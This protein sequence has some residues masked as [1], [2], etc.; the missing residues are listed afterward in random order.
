[1]PKLY[2]F[3]APN[4]D[5]SPDSATA[6]RLGSIFSGA[7]LKRL[8]SPLNQSEYVTIPS[9]L[10]NSSVK[11][12]FSDTASKSVHASGGA[13]AEDTSGVARAVVEFVSR[14]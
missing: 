4:F 7:G 8:T 1:M 10:S 2:Y 11:T 3:R 13:F 14:I 6:P 12:G 5:I 9:H